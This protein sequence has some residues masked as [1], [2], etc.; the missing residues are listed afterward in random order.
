LGKD[1]EW[2]RMDMDLL[3]HTSVYCA[4]LIDP[5]K[6]WRHDSKQLAKV[7]TDLFYERTGPL[8]D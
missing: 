7:I 1:V 4:D 8:M 3:N 6:P 2:V 5:E